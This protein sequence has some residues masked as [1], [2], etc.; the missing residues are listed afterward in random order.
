L[1]G[2]CDQDRL[3][4]FYAQA[5][6]FVLASFAEGIPVVLMEAMSMEIPCL[7]TWITGIPELIRHGVD[8]WLVPPGNERQ[9]AEAIA[10]LADNPALRQQLGKAARVRVQKQYELARNVEAL[11]S[12]YA[13]RLA[14]SGDPSDES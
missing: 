5:D 8:G 14:G 4:A 11:A 9:L 7:A 1:E 13:R 2:P 6:L 10:C 12:I 3:R